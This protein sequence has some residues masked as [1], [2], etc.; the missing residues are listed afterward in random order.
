MSASAP[1]GLG[2]H[3]RGAARDEAIDA[4]NSGFKRSPVGYD[5]V[6]GRGCYDRGNVI[7]RQIGRT[8][9]KPPRKPIKLDQRQRYRELI[10]DCNEH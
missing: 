5:C 8:E 10:L 7:D 9:N 2:G 1:S 6:H 3:D 4:P